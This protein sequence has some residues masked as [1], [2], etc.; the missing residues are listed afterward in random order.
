MSKLIHLDQVGLNKLTLRRWLE[1]KESLHGGKK[2]W[3]AQRE[4]ID[5]RTK[6]YT[7]DE[8]RGL[9]EL[10]RGEYAGKRGADKRAIKRLGAYLTSTRNST[11]QA[12][13]KKLAKLS[14]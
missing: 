12:V 2:A 13:E 14:K 1:A 9:L 3:K 11:V 6:S 10:G 5:R 4:L 8:I 7:V